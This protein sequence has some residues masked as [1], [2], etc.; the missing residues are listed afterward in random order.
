MFI[1]HEP[2]GM[3][4]QGVAPI[5][6]GTVAR[7]GMQPA[8]LCRVMQI[9][10]EIAPIQIFCVADETELCLDKTQQCR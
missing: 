2:F 6:V 5:Q 3:R 7:D 1:A 9:A 4:G 10:G 8:L